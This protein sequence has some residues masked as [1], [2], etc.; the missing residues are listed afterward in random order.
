LRGGLASHLFQARGSGA[1]S[2]CEADANAAALE[3]VVLLALNG[4]VAEGR[5]DAA[6]G[7]SDRMQAQAKCSE[8]PGRKAV[9]RCGSKDGG[10][11]RWMREGSKYVGMPVLRYLQDYKGG[12]ADG[13]EA[14]MEDAEEGAAAYCKTGVLMGWLPAEQSEFVS[15]ETGRPAALWRLVYD[16]DRYAAVQSALYQAEHGHTAA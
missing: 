10:R 14:A 6:L 2:A 8:K 9:S 1:R 15:E 11:S 12:E 4:C 3:H 7:T 5:L 16:S 13:C